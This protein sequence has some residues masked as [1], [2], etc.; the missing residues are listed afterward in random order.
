MAEYPILEFQ[1]PQHRGGVAHLQMVGCAAAGTG[2]S[3]P[4][5]PG[6]SRAHDFLLFAGGLVIPF[7]S[8][9]HRGGVAHMVSV[10][11]FDQQAT[12]FQSP[13]HRGGVA[14]PIINGGNCEYRQR[15]V[16]IPSAPGRSRAPQDVIGPAGR[17]AEVSIPSAPGRS[18]AP[19]RNQFVEPPTQRVS[20]PSAPGRSRAHRKNSHESGI[21]T[22]VSIPSAPGRSRARDAVIEGKISG[23]VGFNPLSTGAESRT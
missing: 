16:S 20:I 22:C 23:G 2:V 4:S 1:S 6:R 9:Q 7:Q 19:G 15:I 13:Q 8:P 18:R 21:H 5:A 12:L 14:H 3:I 10:N 11:T 17:V